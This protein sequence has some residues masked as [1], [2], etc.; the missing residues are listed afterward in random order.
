MWWRRPPSASHTLPY[1]QAQRLSLVYSVGARYTILNNYEAFDCSTHHV[2]YHKTRGAG[3]DVPIHLDNLQ[4]TGS[5]ESLVDCGH[6][7]IGVHDCF[8]SYDVGVG[9]TGRC[10]FSLKLFNYFHSRQEKSSYRK[11]MTYSLSLSLPQHV[12]I[13]W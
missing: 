9:C 11:P 3:K 6:R 1:T 8:H 12:H 10:T 2:V 5:E 13:N 7:G 4:C